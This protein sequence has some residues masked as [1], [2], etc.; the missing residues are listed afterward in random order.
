MAYV[1]NNARK[2]YLFDFLSRKYNQTFNYTWIFVKLLAVRTSKV[3]VHARD[4]Y[5]HTLSPGSQMALQL[6]SVNVHNSTIIVI[7]FSSKA[8]GKRGFKRLLQIIKRYLLQELMVQNHTSFPN[9]CFISKC[10]PYNL[11]KKILY[12]QEK[13]TRCSSSGSFSIERIVLVAGWALN[14]KKEFKRNCLNTMV[15][16][17]APVH[18]SFS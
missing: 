2:G 4:T 7:G 10:Q 18:Q 1:L 9:Q 16:F 5:T 8:I 13:C 6:C 17:P 15:Y 14:K 3:G 12:V 11:C